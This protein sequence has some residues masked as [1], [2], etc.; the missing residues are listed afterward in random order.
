MHQPTTV[1]ST[2]VARRLTAFVVERFPFAL[3]PVH[4]AIEAPGGLSGER[5]AE[6]DALR[7]PFEAALR[8]GLS[9]R[10]PADVPETTPGVKAADRFGAA[11]DEIAAACDGVLRR[12]AIRASL[13]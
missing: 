9:A 5:E 3:E 1:T 7:A 10:G 8:L 2:S 12:A 6:I 11:I 13:S 4:A